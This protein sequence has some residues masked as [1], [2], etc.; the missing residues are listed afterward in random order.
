MEITEQYDQYLISCSRFLVDKYKRMLSEEADNSSRDS[1]SSSDSSGSP[2]HKRPR[3]PLPFITFEELLKIDVEDILVKDYVDWFFSLGPE[4]DENEILLPQN[5]CEWFSTLGSESKASVLNSSDYMQW[6]VEKFAPPLEFPSSA[7][8]I[9][10]YGHLALE[11]Y[12]KNNKCDYEYVRDVE[13][14]ECGDSAHLN[15]YGRLKVSP[16]RPESEAPQRL[17]FA[18]VDLCDTILE[19]RLLDSDEFGDDASVLHPPDDS[20]C[21]VCKSGHRNPLEVS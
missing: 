12:N 10:E 6:Y 21:P 9:E 8:L 17:F 5:Y 20:Y 11:Y 18:K 2:P 14:N 3:G 7:D 15:F 1:D 4:V 19:C 13:L 16:S